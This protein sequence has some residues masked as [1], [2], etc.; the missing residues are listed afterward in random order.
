LTI[1]I[2]PNQ[3]CPAYTLNPT[4]SAP[5]CTSIQLQWT[6]AGDCTATHFLAIR[7][8]IGANPF[9]DVPNASRPVVSTGTYT[10]T[11]LTESTTYEVQ[12]QVV[13]PQNA[14][15]DA[16]AWITVGNVTT[17]ASTTISSPGTAS[18]TVGQA[19][20]YTL[21]GTNSPTSLTITPITPAPGLTVSG[22]TLSGTPTATGTFSYSLVVAN[23]CGSDTGTL[24][25]TVQ[26]P[27]PPPIILLTQARLRATHGG[28]FQGDISLPLAGTLS[29]VDPRAH[30]IAR[31][32]VL[33]FNNPSITSITVIPEVGMMTLGTPIYAGGN[34][35]RIPITGMSNND[36]YRIKITSINGG[37]ISGNDKVRWRIIRGDFDGNGTVNS[38]DVANV[39]N[40]IGQSISNANFRADINAD[41]NLGALDVT[42][43]QSNLGAN[44]AP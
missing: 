32:L 36:R 4:A 44:V 34:Q 8:R 20:S 14:T 22:N 21:T 6:P 2:V 11:G 12:I 33:F 28:G 19:F 16:S 40:R 3:S 24:S 13:S 41:G 29:G 9:T 18:A 10:I 27:P 35:V 38:V 42:Q 23:A 43:A 5:T 30:G 7:Y 25:I 39:T 26:V 17:P 1:Q 15:P 37:P 31:E